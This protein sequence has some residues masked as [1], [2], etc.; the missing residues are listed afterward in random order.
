LI[1]SKGDRS[2][3]ACHPQATTSRRGQVSLPVRLR[4]LCADPNSHSQRAANRPL[5]T[6]ITL[7]W[8][9]TVKPEEMVRLRQL[10]FK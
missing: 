1:A 7:G 5:L 9:L 10:E 3:P 6:E 4:Q 8:G 2:D